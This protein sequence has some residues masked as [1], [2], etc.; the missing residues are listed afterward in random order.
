MKTNKLQF[1]NSCQC[2]SSAEAI[3]A[4]AFQATQVSN[5]IGNALLGKLASGKQSRKNVLKN[6]LVNWCWM[7]DLIHI[8]NGSTVSIGLL[9]FT[10]IIKNPDLPDQHLRI[11]QILTLHDMT[12]DR[13]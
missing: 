11:I 2:L 1:I 9:V 3:L 13:I 12:H 10:L 6:L 7:I 4:V 8:L 5:R